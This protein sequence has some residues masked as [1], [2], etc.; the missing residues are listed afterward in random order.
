MD[1]V[2]LGESDPATLGD[3][4]LRRKYA[5]FAQLYGDAGAQRDVFRPRARGQQQ[6]SERR[7]ER[8]H[9][10]RRLG[11]WRRADGPLSS[12]PMG[13]GTS[14]TSTRCG[15]EKANWQLDLIQ[16]GSTSRGPSPRR[17]WCRV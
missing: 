5:F 8:N 3:R 10:R 12:W 11:T 4:S 17:P 14:L 2:S 15:V 16:T 6:R 1:K 13:D 9:G 7:V